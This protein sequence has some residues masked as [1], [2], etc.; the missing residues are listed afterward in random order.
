MTD[1]SYDHYA[2]IDLV[3][4]ALG[5]PLYNIFGNHD[6]RPSAS[7]EQFR[8]AATLKGLRAA[9]YSVR[10]GG[11]RF[12]FLNTSD[13]ATHSALKSSPEYDLAK[14]WLD[15]LKLAGSPS[16]KEYNGAIG[17]AQLKWLEKELNA[18]ER[19][20]EIAVVSCHML[21]LPSACKESLWN[22]REVVALLESHP[23]VKAVF[24]GHRHSGGYECRGGIHYVNFLGMVEG[25]ANRYAVVHI[26]PAKGGF[27]SGGKIIIDGHGDE[28]DRE[29]EF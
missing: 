17:A 26:E 27:A 3:K 22:S 7:E 19:K 25:E 29:L 21:L 4:R 10:K 18:A 2:D 8:E 13:I 28:P 9:Y 12:I 15:S 5:R 24:C 23:C 1:R 16:A 6:F 20:G 14:R 11:V